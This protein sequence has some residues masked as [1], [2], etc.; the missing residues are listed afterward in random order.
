[1]NGKT[2]AGTGEK[3]LMVKD[4][5][6]DSISALRIILNTKANGKTVLDMDSEHWNSINKPPTKAI[7]RK[8]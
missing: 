6:K 4:T 5:E 2:A 1:M 3:Y 7:S 8:G